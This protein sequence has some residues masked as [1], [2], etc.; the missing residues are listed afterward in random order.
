M[1]LD[2][3]QSTL[4]KGTTILMTRSKQHTDKYKSNSNKTKEGSFIH[5]H[6]KEKHPGKEPNMKLQVEK[7]FRD[8]LSRQIT[9]SVYIYRTEQQT[10]YELMN[11]KSEWNA[12][13]LYTVRR[14]IGHG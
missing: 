8:N 2:A 6:L 14:E 4:V 12:P 5:R 7:T 9:E 1:N 13:T 3:K 11:T 10:E